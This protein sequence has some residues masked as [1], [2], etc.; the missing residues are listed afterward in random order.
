MA[1]ATRG[2]DPQADRAKVRAD[3]TVSEL[4]DLY[5]EQGVAMKKPS[6]LATDKGRIERHIKPIL[7]NKRVNV[8]TLP[9]VE[10]WMQDVASGRTASKIKPSMAQVKAGQVP[11]D[12]ERRRLKD[13]MAK[14]G[15]GTATR[16]AGLLGGIFE[17]A[18]KRK[19]RPDNPVRGLKR[20]RDRKMER[21]L[22]PT[23]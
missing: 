12:A 9:D 11:K 20:Y 8:V 17:F 10:R 23:G 4:C 16:T 3:I 18:V 5:L 22:S 2:A 1:S 19:M 14:G 21:F 13:P 7:G 15:K 6:T